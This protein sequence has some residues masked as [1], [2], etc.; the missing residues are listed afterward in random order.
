MRLLPRHLP[1]VALLLVTPAEFHTV[2]PGTTSVR[3]I[4]GAGSFALVARGC[5]G[6]NLSVESVSFS[7]VAGEVRHRKGAGV[8]GIR[9]GF[10]SH[11]GDSDTIGWI[12]PYVGAEWSVGALSIGYLGNTDRFPL[13][14][15]STEDIPVSVGVRLGAA[16]RYPHVTLAMAAGDPLYSSGGILQIGAGVRS[17]RGAYFWV[18]AGGEP[19]DT[20]GL[21]LR[22]DVPLGDRYRLLL[23][24]RL[25]RSEGAAENA[26]AVGFERA[27]VH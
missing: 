7:E 22:T 2:P 4:G 25:G 11:E 27:F 5:D 21:A 13:G 3:V 12:N 19:Y 14:A 8:A 26:V 16:T 24:A 15:G 23:R 18:G 10:V 20:G 1:L 6:E 17:P 9:G